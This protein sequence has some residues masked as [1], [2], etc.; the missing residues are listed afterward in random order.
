MWAK[1]RWVCVVYNRQL[2]LPVRWIAFDGLRIDCGERTH[3]TG[4][5]DDE[6][7]AV[8]QLSAGCGLK[9]GGFM[10]CCNRQLK[11]P[12]RCIAFD[13]CVLTAV[14]AFT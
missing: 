14:N 3:I 10:C 13:G 6:L 1:A 4:R 12:V 11:L 8:A 9:P 2:K 5:N 7:A